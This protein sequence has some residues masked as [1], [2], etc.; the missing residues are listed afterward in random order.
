MLPWSRVLLPI[1]PTGAHHGETVKLPRRSRRSSHRM[2]LMATPWLTRAGSGWAA[3]VAASLAPLLGACGEES[4]S[5][6]LEPPITVPKPPTLDISQ[7]S[8]RP[9]AAGEPDQGQAVVFGEAGT[10]DP[11][12]GIVRAYN[13][14]DTSPPVDAPVDDAGGFELRLAI[15]SGNTLR[16]ELLGLEGSSGPK[17]LVVAGLGA[18]LEP[19]VEPL[20]A[21]LSLDSGNLMLLESGESG[22]L[23]VEGWCDGIELAAPRP[24]SDRDRIRVGADKDWPLHLENGVPL[25]LHVEV[26]GGAPGDE[27]LFF[28]EATAPEHDRR[29][30]SVRLLD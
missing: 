27:Y 14:D 12:G 11:A 28:V 24:R 16:L 18:P 7:I 13:L 20:G 8:C 21:C 4:V 19:L 6:K 17:D 10:A 3:L 2:S 25:P 22:E 23:G 29:A 5:P 1:R 15:T 26:L 30:V 9:S